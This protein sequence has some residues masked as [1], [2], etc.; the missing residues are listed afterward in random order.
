MNVL[1]LLMKPWM[2]SCRE[3]RDRLSDYLEGDLGARTRRRIGRHLA[4]CKHCQALLQ[5]LTRTLEQLRS[6]GSIDQGSPEPAT[7]R[8][9]IE[10]IEREQR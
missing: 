7:V 2:A 4:R 5:S 10:R 8:A 9:V 6:L 1:S 3:T